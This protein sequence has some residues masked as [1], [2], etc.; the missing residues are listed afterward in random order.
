M[1]RNKISHVYTI[2]YVA[3][4]LGEDVGFLHEVS[5]DMEPEDGVMSVVG[6][7]EQSTTAF[8]DDGIESLRDYIREHRASTGAAPDT[9]KQSD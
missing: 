5:G 4:L 2:D 8:S 1:Q 7:N 9:S 3:E 6:P